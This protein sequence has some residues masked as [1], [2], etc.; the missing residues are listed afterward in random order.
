M[1]FAIR[2]G[3]F[4]K[5]KVTSGQM[6]LKNHAMQFWVVGCCIMRAMQY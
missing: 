5:E 2:G 4:K 1:Y 3:V 6:A